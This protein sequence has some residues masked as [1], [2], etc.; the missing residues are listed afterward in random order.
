MDREHGIGVGIVVVT[1]ALFIVLGVEVALLPNGTLGPSPPSSLPIPGGT[2]FALTEV[3]GGKYWVG[4]PFTVNAGSGAHLYRITGKWTGEAATGVLV[5]LDDV[6]FALYPGT[7]FCSS[8]EPCPA[9]PD[10]FT[11]NGN[12]D[13]YLYT[14]NGSVPGWAV[15][16][17]QP[18]WSTSSP[19]APADLAVTYYVVFAGSQPDVI[20]VTQTFEVQALSTS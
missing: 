11:Y 5:N 13:V 6:P 12:L 3:M 10:P 15:P 1:V 8:N 14:N 2:T 19:P 9:P 16:V 20:E 7:P 4:V 17:V 18:S